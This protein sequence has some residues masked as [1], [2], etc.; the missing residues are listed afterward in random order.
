[1]EIGAFCKPAERNYSP[2]EREATDIVRGLKDTKYYTLG[3]RDLWVTTD[4]QPL[5]GVLGDKSLVDIDN[6]RLARIKEKLM[7]WRLQVVYNPGKTQNAADAISRC[8]PL[9]PMFVSEGEEEDDDT[10]DV[11]ECWRLSWTRSTLL[12]SM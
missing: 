3:C 4:Y 1:M 11:L 7:W 8:K 12:S 10:K 2:I 6:K 9:H 5:F